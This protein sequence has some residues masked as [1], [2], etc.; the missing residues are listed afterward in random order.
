V[1]SSNELVELNKA[2]KRI[3]DVNAIDFMMRVFLIIKFPPKHS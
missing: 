2:A 3:E 1:V